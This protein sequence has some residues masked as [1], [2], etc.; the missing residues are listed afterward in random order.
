M[1]SRGYGVVLLD[2]PGGLQRAAKDPMSRR[3]GRARSGR[4][5]GAKAFDRKQKTVWRNLSFE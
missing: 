2:D 3:F 4:P 5:G 1:Q